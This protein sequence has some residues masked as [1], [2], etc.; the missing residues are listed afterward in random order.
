MQVLQAYSERGACD[1]A[2]AMFAVMG[3]LDESSV[4]TLEIVQVC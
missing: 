3:M 1:L 4:L 2:G